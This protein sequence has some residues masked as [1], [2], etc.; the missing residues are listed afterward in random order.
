MQR[1]VTCHLIHLVRLDESKLRD[2]LQN[3]VDE[4]DVERGRELKEETASIHFFQS[5]L[6][7]R[8]L[9]G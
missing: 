6:L 9:K 5:I 4:L 8:L 3:Y 7:L 1:G 2:A